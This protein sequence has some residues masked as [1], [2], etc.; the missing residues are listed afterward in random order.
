MALISQLVNA[1]Q[2]PIISTTEAFFIS[3]SVPLSTYQKLWIL[4]EAA[5]RVRGMNGVCTGN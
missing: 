5:W 3:T 2:F 4:L 1:R